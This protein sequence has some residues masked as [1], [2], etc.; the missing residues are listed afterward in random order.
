MA[1]GNLFCDCCRDAY[2]AGLTDGLKIGF[3]LGHSVGF[4]QGRRLGYVEGY[5]E[6]TLGIE[7][8]PAYKPAIASKMRELSG[9]SSPLLLPSSKA[10]GCL[11]GFP[12]THD[13][14][15]VTW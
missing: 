15:L 11:R 3:K 2:F 7:P 12:C 8:P 13:Y 14:E 5:A 1:C 6:A 4:K 10:C 9:T